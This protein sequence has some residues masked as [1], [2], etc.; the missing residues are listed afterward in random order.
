MHAQH[1][2]TLMSTHVKTHTLKCKYTMHIHTCIFSHTKHI[3]AYKMHIHPHTC[4]REHTHA[5]MH[6]HTHVHI[7]HICIHRDTHTYHTEYEKTLIFLNVCLFWG[8]FSHRTSRSEIHDSWVLGLQ[9]VIW[10]GLESFSMAR[11]TVWATESC[12]KC[13]VQRRRVSH[14]CLRISEWS[15]HSD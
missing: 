12:G 9:G 2:H 10:S 6:S 14:K 15:N 7:P 13:E 1:A 4:T 5:Y 11:E 8:R 3:Y